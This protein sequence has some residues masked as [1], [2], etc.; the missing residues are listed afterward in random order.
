MRLNRI[1]VLAAASQ[2]LRD[3]ARQSED[4]RDLYFVRRCLDSVQLLQLRSYASTV[5]LRSAGGGL[6]Q[7]LSETI[8]RCAER[9]ELGGWLI[10]SYSQGS[11][12]SNHLVTIHTTNV[13]PIHARQPGRPHCTRLLPNNVFFY[14]CTYALRWS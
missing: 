13:A 8:P 2:S 9:R 4:S 12:T 10:P 3:R 5:S 14:L 6:V 7:R 11:L 1:R